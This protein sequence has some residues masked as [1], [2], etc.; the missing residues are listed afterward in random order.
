MITYE[1]K[2]VML[3]SIYNMKIDPNMFEDGLAR[4]KAYNMLGYD[5]I[6]SLGVLNDNPEY[7]PMYATENAFNDD[8]WMV[9]M[10]AY[11]VLGFTEDALNDI[12]ED[13]RHDAQEYH[14]LKAKYTEDKARKEVDLWKLEKL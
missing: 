9:R 10:Y 12:D 1:E 4:H 8:D 3:C 11:R 14:G 5:D 7:I 6:D 2:I 13:I